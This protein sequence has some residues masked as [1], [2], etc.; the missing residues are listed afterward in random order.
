MVLDPIPQSL[1]VHFF[2]SR[3][4]P[5]TSL[6]TYLPVSLSLRPLSVAL[7]TYLLVSLS[8]G[9][10]DFL[11]LRP[12][13]VALSTYLS[14]SPPSLCLP[15][16]YLPISLSLGLFDFLSLCLTV[17]LSLC[18]IFLSPYGVATISRLLKSIGLFCR[19]SSF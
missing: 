1:P 14:V 12:L 10:F 16:T 7:S 3:P 8:L 17:S 5:P 18:P 4:Q 9:L 15:N 11:S 6:S 2:G 13:S 19:I